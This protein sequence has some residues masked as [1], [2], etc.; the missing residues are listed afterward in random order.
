MALAEVPTGLARGLAVGATGL[1]RKIAGH[2]LDVGVRSASLEP[3]QHTLQ[4][5]SRAQSAV[6]E[7]AD[8]EQ[9]NGE[10]A[11]RRCVLRQ[12]GDRRG[13]DTFAHRLST[14]FDFVTRR[15]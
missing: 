3:R 2:A 4:R 12:P 15:L 11:T 9:R 13:V 6:G 7:T 8:D 14:S 10:R 1:R 5:L